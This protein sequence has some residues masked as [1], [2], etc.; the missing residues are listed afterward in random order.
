MHGTHHSIVRRETDSNWGTI[1]SWWDRLHRSLR[2]DVPQDDLIIGVPA[3]RE[4]RELTIGKLLLMPFR[5]QRDWQLPDG[6]VPQREPQ[7]AR[8]LA[9]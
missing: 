3:W 8:E 1:F 4:E 6:A 2:L 7:P 5:P 9:P